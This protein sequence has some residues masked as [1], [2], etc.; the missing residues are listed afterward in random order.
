MA[1]SH[2]IASL[3]ALGGL[4]CAAAWAQAPAVPAPP[5]VTTNV[6]GSLPQPT[7]P[8]AQAAAS[9]AAAHAVGCLIGPMRVADVG[10]PVVGVVDKMPVDI[11]DSVKQGQPVMVL[12][13]EVE[14]AG[15]RA[16]HTRWSQDA[17]LLAAQASLDLARQRYTRAAELLGDGFV[18][19]Q[20]VEQARTELQLAEQ[21]VAQSRGQRQVL[22]TDLDVVK[23][24]LNQRTVRAPFDGV[25]V[26][27][28]RHPGERVEDRP[29]LRLA[30]L[31][32][33][34]VDLVVPATRFGQYA[35][36]TAVSVWPELPGATAVDAKVTH[37]DRVID[38]A[39]NAFRVRLSRP[40]PGHRLPA[41][42]RCNV[43]GSAAVAVTPAIA[44][45]KPNGAVTPTAL[46]AAKSSA[47]AAPRL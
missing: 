47:T 27:R 44:P 9:K 8:T 19:S 40:N 38:A 33:L 28:F 23:A 16:A 42:A 22:A 36:N 7:R 4:S 31:D 12:R 30:T 46:P 20:A 32:P 18:S 1:F 29:V 34:R 35:L 41:G 24:Q 14:A 3:F 13:A 21:R 2:H 37:I 15:E 11:G 10:S 39:S 5:R 17:D 43:E 25:V 45:I 26:E 6:Q